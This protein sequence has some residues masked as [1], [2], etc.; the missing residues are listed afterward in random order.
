[1]ASALELELQ[2]VFLYYGEPVETAEGMKAEDFFGMIS[3]FATSLQVS[4]N[5]AESLGPALSTPYRNPLSRCTKPKRNKKRLR[6]R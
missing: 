3:S 4:T 5:Q 2:S 6:R 1:M